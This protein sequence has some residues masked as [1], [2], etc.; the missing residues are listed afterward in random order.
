MGSRKRTASGVILN[1]DLIRPGVLAAF[2][3]T[4][5]DTRRLLIGA[6][7]LLWRGVAS[8]VAPFVLAV[9]AALLVLF[10][11]LS[12]LTLPEVFLCVVTCLIIDGMIALFRG[13]SAAINIAQE[14]VS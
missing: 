2:Y 6:N 13:L 14:A 11:N 1:A 4:P 5:P 3:V 7:S 12:N 9:F 8:S 10:V